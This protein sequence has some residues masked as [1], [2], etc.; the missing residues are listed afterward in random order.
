MQYLLEEELV[1]KTNQRVL[2]LDIET[3]PNLGYIWGKYEQNVIAYENEW[4]M[5]SFSV[6]WLGAKKTEVF[7]LPDFTGYAKNKDS[8]E[9]L[10]KKLWEYLDEADVV[11]AHNGDAFDLKKSNA[12]FIYHRME[13]PTPYKTVDTLKVARRYFK[14]NSNKLDD[15]AVHLGIG[16]KAETGGFK[17]WLGCMEGDMKVWATMKKYNKQDVVL[18][19]K[20]YLRLRSWMTNHPNMNIINATINHCPNCG[21]KDIIKRGFAFTRV[22]MKQRYHCQS[23][24]AWSQGGKI[25]CDNKIN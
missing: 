16:K 10:V 6:K 24:G 19:E 13:P 12:R 11:I 18:L 5:L 20:V 25:P 14:F 4:F 7:G 1:M 21:K 8:D 17:T 2:L 15:L 23:C 3:S 9:K 22:S